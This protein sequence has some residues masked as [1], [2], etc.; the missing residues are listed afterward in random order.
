MAFAP[1]AR[2][3]EDFFVSNSPGDGGN[4]QGQNAKGCELFAEAHEQS[5]LSPTKEKRPTACDRVAE[6]TFL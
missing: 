6:V 1:L 3:A 2:L 4:R 5:S